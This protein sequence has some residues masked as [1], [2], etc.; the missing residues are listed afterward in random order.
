[1]DD[2]PQIKLK[3]NPRLDTDTVS[4]SADLFSLLNLDNDKSINFFV[5]QQQKKL[6]ISILNYE[7]IKNTVILNPS[8][9]RQFYLHANQKYGIAVKN[10]EIRLGPVVGI[11]AEV[12]NEKDKQF[13]G[14]TFFIKQL[15]TCGRKLGEICF[16]FSPFSIDWKRKKIYGYIYGKKGWVKS[17]FPMPDVVYLRGKAYSLTNSRTR[18]KIEKLGV[19]FLNPPLIGKWQTYKIIS[20]NPNLLPYLPDTRLI[21]SFKQ[22]DNMIKK[23]RAV[24]LKPVTGSQGKNIVKVVKN[25]KSPEYYYQYQLNNRLYR[26]RARSLAKLRSS[27]KQ[28]MGRRTYIIQKQIN[29]LKSQGNIV[30][31]RILVQK[32]HQGIWDITGM[33]CRIGKNGSITS[34][35]SSGGSGRKLETILKRNF[36]DE[37]KREQII[38]NIKYVSLE[39]AKTLEKF[40][41]EAG[42]MGIDIGIDNNGKIWFIEANLKPAR[43]VFSLIG[44]RQIRLESVKKPMLYARYLAGF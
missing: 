20:T 22:V 6:N 42:E 36:P 41:G 1:M 28:V 32:D 40:I 9:I 21:T 8:L 29:L 24:Y 27:L 39:A 26:G 35:I 37:I 34:N 5:G 43:Q 23:H 16:A 10:S 4:I 33:A 12:F 31:V 19:K 13:G 44:E 25:K 14:Q 11:M 7:N 15:L 17:G 2:F 38:D 18:R 30:D 3:S